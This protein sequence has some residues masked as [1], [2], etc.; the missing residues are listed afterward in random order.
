MSR[1]RRKPAAKH[2]AHLTAR[3][4]QALNDRRPPIPEG[5]PDQAAEILITSKAVGMRV[6]NAVQRSGVGA[7]LDALHEAQT[8]GR[9]RNRKIS[10]T[11]LLVGMHIAAYHPSKTY[12]RSDVALALMGLD[13]AVAHQLGLC[14]TRRWTKFCYKTVANR[15]KQLELLLHLGFFH[16][17][18]YY[19]LKWLAERLLWASIPSTVLR[20]EI[21]AAALDETSRPTWA[22][23]VIFKNQ[24]EL[25]REALESWRK[26]NPGRPDPTDPDERVAM[27][28][29]EAKKQGY[30]VGA[31]GRL[32][33][34]KDLEARVGWASATSTEP[35]GYYMG[36][37]LTLLVACPSGPPGGSPWNTSLGDEIPTYIIALSVDPAGSGKSGPIGREVVESGRKIAPNLTDVVADRGYTTKRET[38]LRMLHRLGLNVT[39]DHTQRTINRPTTETVGQTHKT[40]Q[41]VHMHCGT[42]LPVWT[43]TYWQ[44][45]PARLLSPNNKKQLAKYYA[46]RATFLG[47]PDRG[48]SWK[49]DGTVAGRRFR[50]RTCGRRGALP[51]NI[52]LLGI[53]A[54]GVCCR[55]GGVT[56]EI[57]KLDFYQKHLYGTPAWCVS[58]A[59]RNIVETVNSMLKPDKGR[60]IGRCQAFGLAANTMASI[61]LAVVH[62]L[63]LTVK[64]KRAKAQ[65]NKAPKTNTKSATDNQA[66]QPGD[67]DELVEDADTP[68]EPP[69]P[70]QRAT[71]EE[72]PPNRAPP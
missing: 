53:P 67:T 26:Q 3:Q 10:D 59:R 16:D 4:R 38:F 22:K 13:A 31:D 40:R 42:I 51:T 34:G 1:R 6:L 28:E 52:P 49:K 35:A 7:V 24:Q 66:P 18:K 41:T 20:E 64:A 30:E 39:M 69:N 56:I 37:G 47:W 33:H 68:D 17:R 57:E 11:A 5:H 8:G 32:I 23:T 2:A 27:I 50:C 55:G 29:A 21:V 44:R 70:E 15:V 14:T 36:Y 25:Q 48:V 54:N 43:T 19:D 62:N 72:Q 63:K 45:P 9:G 58:Y 71:G 61:A 60:E 46:N 65:A 12:H